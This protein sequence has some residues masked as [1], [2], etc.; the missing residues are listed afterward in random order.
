MTEKKRK[1]KN[2]KKTIMLCVSGLFTDKKRAPA[3][4]RRAVGRTVCRFYFSGRERK[5]SHLAGAGISK[6]EHIKDADLIS[7]KQFYKQSK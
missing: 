7:K 4:D 2:E 3:S 6:D 1:K 5:R